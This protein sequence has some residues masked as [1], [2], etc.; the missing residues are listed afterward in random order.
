MRTGDKSPKNNFTTESTE[1]KQTHRAHKDFLLLIPKPQPQ[2]N[3]T[4]RHKEHKEKI[5]YFLL[6]TALYC[7]FVIFYYL[8]I[9]QL[10][11]LTYTLMLE[12]LINDIKFIYSGRADSRALFMRVRKVRTLR[13]REA[14]LGRHRK[15][16]ESATENI[17]PCFCRVRVKRRGKSSPDSW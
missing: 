15:V 9:F 13:V 12:I 4:Q 3:L 11:Y 7:L 10:I 5:C 14:P 8:T 17:P 6:L 16:T 2:I 1:K